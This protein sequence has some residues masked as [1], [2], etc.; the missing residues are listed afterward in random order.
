MRA[1][2]ADVGE[3]FAVGGEGEGR[4]SAAVEEELVVEWV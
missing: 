2:V 3:L 4:G 1:A